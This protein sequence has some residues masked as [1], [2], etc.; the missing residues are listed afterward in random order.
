LAFEKKQQNT[1]FILLFRIFKKQITHKNNKQ[2]NKK[3]QY[4]RKNSTRWLALVLGSLSFLEPI[5]F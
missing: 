2:N 1:I 3:W 4:K 5:Y